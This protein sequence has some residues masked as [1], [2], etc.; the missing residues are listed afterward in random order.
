L[1]IANEKLEVV[2]LCIVGSGAGGGVLARELAS[3]GRSVTVLEVGAPTSRAA[4]ATYRPDWELRAADFLPGDRARDRITLGPASDPFFLI[5]FKGV[6]GSTMHYEGQCNRLHPRDLSR[7][8]EYGVGADWPLT[9]EDLVPHYDRVESMLGV[10]GTL[11]N[12]FDPPRRAFPNPPID[13]SCGVKRVVAGCER[14]GLHPAHASLAILSRAQSGRGAC[15]FCGSCTF[16]CMQAAISN[17]GETYIPAAERDGAKIRHGCMATRVR[18]KKDGRHVDG[19]EF[20]DSEGALH[21]QPAR[22]VAVCGNSVETARL[23]LMSATPDHPD[24]LANGSGL[25]GR[26]FMVHTHVRV[27]GLFDDRVDAYR[28]PNINGVVSD[29]YDS[30]AKRGYLGGY[31]IALRNA[32]YGPVIFFDRWL[33]EDQVFGADFHRRMEREFGHSV[34]VDAYGELFPDEA[35]RVA[36]DPEEKDSFGLPVPQITVRHSENS[37]KM[38]AHMRA[39]LTDIMNAA[40][41][42]QTRVLRDANLMGTHLMG[43]CRMGDDPKNSVCNSFGRTHDIANLFVADGSLFPTATPANPTLTIQAL[44]TRVALH[45][46]ELFSRR[47]I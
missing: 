1:S 41:A 10:S 38:T 25:V 7:F 44:A 14:I 27:G 34:D 15:N 40:G 36:L 42:V 8:S 9:Y 13:F 21:F 24:G 46:D 22:A 6:G 11:D 31:L 35:N 26:N 18:L 2:D 33:S 19:V 28:G 5:R 45:I 47:D 29:F 17:M 12:P 16:G 32:Q 30:D 39:T 23:L 43:T 3:R 37:R 4:I 20:L